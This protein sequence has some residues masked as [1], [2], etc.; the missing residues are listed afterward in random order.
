MGPP[1]GLKGAQGPSYVGSP[2]LGS[3]LVLEQ[4]RACA[5]VEGRAQPEKH[6]GLEQLTA[7]GCPRC[8]LSWPGLL[9]SGIVLRLLGQGS[10]QGCH[11][12]SHCV[13]REV[14]EAGVCADTT[15]ARCM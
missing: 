14:I 15:V 8:G 13:C 3:G 4:C 1:G 9:A 7:H 12:S 5:G 10:Q 11:C 2:V 6:H